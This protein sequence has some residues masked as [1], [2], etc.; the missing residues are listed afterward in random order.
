VDA[1]VLDDADPRRPLAVARTQPDVVCV[2]EAD[3]EREMRAEP[4]W[5]CVLLCEPVV[6]LTQA[7]GSVLVRDGPLGRELGVLCSGH[8]SAR[9][10]SPRRERESR[11]KA[12]HLAIQVEDPPAVINR[13]GRVSVEPS[14]ETTDPRVEGGEVDAEEEEELDEVEA[15]Q[16][17][18]Q[19]SADG[20]LGLVKRQTVCYV[21]GAVGEKMGRRTWSVLPAELTRT[22]SAC[23]NHQSRTC[24]AA[25]AIRSMFWTT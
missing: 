19:E 15:D 23:G 17:V 7:R 20:I 21:R 24:S 10:G 8:A 5:I 14:A 22:T 4:G 11:S 6:E 9:M 3:F 18:P 13:D 12:T 2:R 25:L 1:L 16:G